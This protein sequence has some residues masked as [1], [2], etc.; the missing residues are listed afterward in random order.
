M[1]ASERMVKQ[2]T[3]WL[4]DYPASLGEDRNGTFTDVPAIVLSA[5][6]ELTY[7][8]FVMKCE[9]ASIPFQ[10]Q[11]K[12]WRLI[13]MLTPGFLSKSSKPTPPSIWQS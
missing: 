12:K 6:S 8:T 11:T 1:P 4:K 5:Y 2:D 3:V 9:L 10:L 13:S 7:G